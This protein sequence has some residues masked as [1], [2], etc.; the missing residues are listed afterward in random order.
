MT[1]YLTIAE[2]QAEFG[3]LVDDL[4]D[5]QIQRRIDRLVAT[6]EAELGHGFGRV[7]IASS[8]AADT[9]AVSAAALTIGGDAYAFADYT[10]L[11]ALV[12]AVN[13]AGEDYSLELLPHV[14]EGTPSTLLAAIT[15]TTCGPAY[16]NRVNLWASGRYEQHS[17][18]RQTH[19]FLSLPLASITSVVESGDTLENTAYWAIPGTSWLIRKYCSC[20]DSSDCRHPRTWWKHN[21]PGNILIDYQPQWWGRPPASLKALLLEGFEGLSDIGP[22]ESESF[23]G[24]YSYRRAASRRPGGWQDSLSG[25]AVRQYALRFMP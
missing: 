7:L 6:L 4:S 11:L 2:V 12:T 20:S 15:A 8:T 3:D 25:S 16:E 24:A 23:G 10:T 17:G 21:Y 1:E 22:M 14:F 13:A 9:V 18:T 19:V 5:G